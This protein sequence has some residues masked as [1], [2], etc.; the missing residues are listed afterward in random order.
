[1]DVI[2]TTTCCLYMCSG[3]ESVTTSDSETEEDE[4]KTTVGLPQLFTLATVVKHS[5]VYA[6]IEDNTIEF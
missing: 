6:P 5:E 2:A 3:T 4:D 1:M